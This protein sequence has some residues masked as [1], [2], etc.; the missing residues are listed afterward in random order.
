MFELYNQIEGMT[1]DVISAFLD[2]WQCRNWGVSCEQFA[3][4]L[5]THITESLT[6]VVKEIT[7]E[8]LE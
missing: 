6:R 3:T 8:E 1:D 5:V 4:L 2:A 7:E